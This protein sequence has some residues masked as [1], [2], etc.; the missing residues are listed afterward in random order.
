M[1]Y[2][3][4]TPSPFIKKDSLHAPQHKNKWFATFECDMF[5]HAYMNMFEHVWT[6][7]SCTFSIRNKLIIKLS[8]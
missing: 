8:I 2:N 1:E 3:L 6:A 5:E 4:H 7:Y